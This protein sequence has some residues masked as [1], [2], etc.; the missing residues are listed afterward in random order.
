MKFLPF[1]LKIFT[2]RYVL[3]ICGFV[4]WMLFFDEKNFFV[5]RSRKAELDAL[6]QKV[7]Y[8]NTQLTTTTTQLNALQNNSAALE[9]YAREKYFMKRNNEEVFVFD[10]AQ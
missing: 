9:K 10:S 2:N 8:Y 5:Q 1:I 7:Q 3:A 6:N 4:V